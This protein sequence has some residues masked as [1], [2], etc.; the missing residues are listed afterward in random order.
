MADVWI[1]IL[2]FFLLVF[3]AIFMILGLSIFGCGVWILFDTNNFIVTVS[4]GSSMR[5]IAG[6]LFIIGLAVVTVSAV[7]YLGALKEI[8][9]FL[10]VYMGF[11]I[12]IFLA[13]LFVTFILLLKKNE[14]IVALSDEVDRIIVD[15]GDRTEGDK[16]DHKWELMD[17]VQHYWHCCGRTNYTNWKNNTY[18]KTLGE[19][20]VYPCSC[21]TNNTC[22]LLPSDL[23]RRFGQGST[24]H[25]TDCQT[26]MEDWILKNAIVILAMD[27]GLALIQVVQFTLS[28]YLTR[29]VVR[30]MRGKQMEDSDSS[31]IA[32]E[33]PLHD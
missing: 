31:S 5:I 28:L 20:D 6:G 16:W 4:S 3:N 11:L 25:T 33:E 12:V 1:Q 19:R 17:T 10:I 7:G 32:H 9:F 22:P 24:V 27:L 21:F 18:I 2:K 15:Y 23:T 14:I 13:Q 29:N 26:H 30:K 8:R